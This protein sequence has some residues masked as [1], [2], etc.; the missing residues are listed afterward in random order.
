MPKRILPKR[1]DA[2]IWVLGGMLPTKQ[3]PAAGGHLKPERQ[4]TPSLIST[5]LAPSSSLL[6]HP[7]N[8]ED[9]CWG[10]RSG[11]RLSFRRGAEHQGRGSAAWAA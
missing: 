11:R 1:P 4:H 7:T 8:D 10:V 9:R 3:H 5:G 2:Q 6:D